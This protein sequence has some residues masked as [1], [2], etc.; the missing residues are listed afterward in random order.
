MFHHE[1]LAQKLLFDIRS[2]A[3]KAAHNADGC[4]IAGGGGHPKMGLMW[5]PWSDR[6]RS[7]DT[8]SRSES[9]TVIGI[10]QYWVVFP[11]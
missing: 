11:F 6:G 8:V 9:I 1:E 5:P 3:G 7:Q 4:S 2:Q 10:F